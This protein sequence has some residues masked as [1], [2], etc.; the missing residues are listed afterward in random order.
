MYKDILLSVD[1]E[2]PDSGKKSMIAAIE[3]A[4]AFGATLHV[5]T[6]VPSYGMSLVGSFFPKGYEAAV[7]EAARVRLHE[8]TAAQIP[9]GVAVQHVV[10]H[11]T[12]HE[13]VLRVA[14]QINA[15][16]IIL[17]ASRPLAGKFLLGPNASRVATHAKCSVLVARD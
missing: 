16:L 11:G 17:G 14:E 7:L 10:G 9:E 2:N 15:D 5:I 3:F 8:F 12:V 4:R 1:L 13:E 6:V